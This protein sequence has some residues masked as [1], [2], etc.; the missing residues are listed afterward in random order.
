M[1]A[2][3]GLDVAVEAGAG[4]EAGYPDAQYQEKGAKLLPERAAIFGQCD[5]VVQVLCYGAN[6]KNGAS[7][8]SLMRGGQVL[9]GFLRPLAS[10]EAVQEVARTGVTAFSVEL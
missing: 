4:I 7:D 6:D 10:P 8:L 5:I 9:V 1:L 2:K 3:A